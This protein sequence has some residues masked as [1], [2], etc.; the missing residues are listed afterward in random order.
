M[1]KKF[2]SNILGDYI[3]RCP[4]MY[5]AC[6]NQQNGN[7]CEIFV[8]LFMTLMET[9]DSVQK[10]SFSHT[11]IDGVRPNLASCIANEQVLNVYHI[12]RNEDRAFGSRYQR[13]KDSS[14]MRE[15]S[16]DR[17]PRGRTKGSKSTKGTKD[18]K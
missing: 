17:R 6:Y 15:K 7:D 3:I 5:P 13:Q 9:S 4:E 2:L 8:M 18:I 1:F 14:T 16:S 12:R 11:I 10:D